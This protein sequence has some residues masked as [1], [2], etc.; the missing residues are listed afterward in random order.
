VRKDNDGLYR[1]VTTKTLLSRANQG[2]DFLDDIQAV[3][4]EELKK[5]N[6]Q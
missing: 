4:K 3:T 2:A 1:V 6:T 5:L